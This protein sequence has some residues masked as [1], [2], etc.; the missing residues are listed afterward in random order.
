MD[1][2]DKLGKKASETYKVTAEKTSKLAKE[3]KLKMKMNE[4][5]SDI[6]GIYKEI[7]KKVYEKHVVKENIN[8]EEELEEEFTKIDVLSAEIESILK[9]CMSLRDK[10]QCEACHT[11]IEKNVQYCPSCGAKQPE[12]VKEEE[13][14]EAKEVEVV[15][16]YENA[17]SENI[18]PENQEDVNE[19]KNEN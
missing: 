13:S 11:E 3:A 15:D 6:E 17:D 14:E 10:K 19:N 4:N 18:N 1:F 8:I 2:F 16:N 5:K 7:G 12:E 9:E